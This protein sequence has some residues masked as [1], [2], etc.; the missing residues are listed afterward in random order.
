M[1]WN[2]NCR[3]FLFFKFDP[4]IFW[5]STWLLVAT[6]FLTACQSQS[7]PSA[8]QAG[9]PASEIASAEPQ[10]ISIPTSSGHSLEGRY[11]PAAIENAPIL[12]LM[13]WSG[14]SL[15]DWDAIARWLQNLGLPADDPENKPWADSSWFPTLDQDTSYAVLSFTYW[16]LGGSGGSEIHLRDSLDVLA[17]ASALAG[18]EP[19]R[20][21]TVGASIGADGALDACYLFNASVASGKNTGNC[22]GAFSLSPA[23]YLTDAFSYQEA[24]SDLS[25]QGVVIYCLA[26]TRDTRAASTCSGIAAPENFHPFIFEGYAHGMSLIDPSL[27]PS[28]PQSEKNTLQIL[29]KFLNE[30]TEK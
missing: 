30:A 8:F 1:G 18:V 12:V 16:P 15:E 17:F 9:Q 19:D 3:S 10:E 5:N 21:L 26:A 2:I 29:I 24:A 23:N 27:F 22:V 14:G 13:H 11:Y 20:I 25:A 6:V 4:K 28:E 7:A